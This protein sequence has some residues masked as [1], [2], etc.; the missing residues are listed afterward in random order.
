MDLVTAGLILGGSQVGQGI[1][2]RL[3]NRDLHKIQKEVLDRQ[4]QYNNDLQ[5]RSRGKFTEAELAAIKANAEPRINAIAG[6]VS[7]RLGASSPAAVALINRARQAP[8]NAAMQA[9]AGQYGESLAN[10]SKSV[11]ERQGELKSDLSF[12]DDLKTILLNYI[13]LRKAGVNLE[14]NKLYPDPLTLG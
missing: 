6:D 10:L 3:A 9:A 4:I 13:E 12:L 2:N 1:Y 14:D 7:A 11:T 5:R 8:I